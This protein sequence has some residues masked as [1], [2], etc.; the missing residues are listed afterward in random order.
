MEKTRRIST[1]SFYYSMHFDVYPNKN[2]DLTNLN[3]LYLILD[4]AWL[5]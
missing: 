1:I 4:G 3:N 5:N 2:P